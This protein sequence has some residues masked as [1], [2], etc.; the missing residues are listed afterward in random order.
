MEKVKEVNPWITKN[1]NTVYENPWIVLS[2]R[3]VITPGGTDG[4]YGKVHFK[5]TAIGILPLDKDYNTWIVGQYR[6]T[7]DEYSWEIPEGGGPLN[8]EPLAAAIRELKEETGISAEKWTPVIELTTSNSVTDE[9]AICYVAQDLSFGE[10][11]PEE[12]E[13]LKI[14]KIP[15]HDLV[16]M[17]LN[18]DITDAMSVATILKV[19]ILIDQGKL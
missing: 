15:F 3:E 6:Y 2:H 16:D 18:G 1:V 7:L 12:T 17:T 13:E 11:E 19:K 9:R 10:A 14:K 4:I 5:N 8:E